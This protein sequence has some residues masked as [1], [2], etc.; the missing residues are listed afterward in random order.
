MLADPKD[1]MFSFAA[2]VLGALGIS[3]ALFALYAGPFTAQP[4]VGT[5]I[6]E[7]AGNM[8]AAALRAVQGLPQPE[9]TIVQPTWDIDRIL[10]A[11]APIL[12]VLGVIASVVAFIRREPM[13]M[14]TYG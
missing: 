7:I 3:V 2:M 6:G 5:Q 12:G 11:A 8:R 13:R 1:A 14:A 9:E 10:M 4:D